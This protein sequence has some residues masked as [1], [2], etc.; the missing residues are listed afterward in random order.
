MIRLFIIEDHLA[1]VLS[2]FRFMFRPQ[3]DGITVTGY[4]K[5]PE[6]TINCAD[7]EKF[8]I[9]ILDL[10]LPGLRPVENIRA[11]KKH[12]PTKPIMI[13]SSEKSS[14]WIN[15]MMDEGAVAYVSKDASREEIAF[16]IKKAASG[17][18]LFS[19]KVGERQN[20]LDIEHRPN[21]T[22]PILSPVET[23]IAKLLSK[24]SKHKEIADQL[25]VSRSTAENILKRMQKNFQTANNIELI[26]ILSDRG[27]I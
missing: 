21:I 5:T 1:L 24:G 17:E 3:R 11:L 26:K 7:P 19:G 23:E 6:E 2:S 13:F 27:L 20:N 22:L 16:S 15:T 10:L 25:G 4:A 8:D 18:Y 9:F 14:S 12:F